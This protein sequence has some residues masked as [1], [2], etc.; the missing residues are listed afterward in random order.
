MNYFKTSV[1]CQCGFQAED[2]ILGTEADHQRDA[3]LYPALCQICHAMTPVNLKELPVM[4]S[5]CKSTKIKYYGSPELL[6]DII[7]PDFESEDFALACSSYEAL[8]PQWG[9]ED[10][11]REYIN[12]HILQI[13]TAPS[14]IY[15]HYNYCPKC[16]EFKLTFNH[17][18]TRNK[19]RLVFQR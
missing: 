11:K 8:Y 16:G 9:V 1:N 2:L 14:L 17:L 6:G 5:T 15:S 4:C 13:A 7:M 3:Y 18:N 10:I 19:H 12:E